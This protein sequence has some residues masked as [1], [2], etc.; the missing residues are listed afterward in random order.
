MQKA[1]SQCQ[2]LILE[3]FQKNIRSLTELQKE[4]SKSGRCRK[5]LEESLSLFQE[6]YSLLLKGSG[7]DKTNEPP[8]CEVME[9][10]VSLF[11]TICC[12]LILLYSYVYENLPCTNQQHFQNKQ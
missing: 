1:Y 8:D 5:S 10:Q 4:E 2:T 3:T 6:A 12:S 9:K 11:F 7:L